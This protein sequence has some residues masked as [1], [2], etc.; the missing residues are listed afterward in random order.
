MITLLPLTRIDQ[1]FTFVD[2][3]GWDWGAGIILSSM[4]LGS[5]HLVDPYP[6]LVDQG[7]VRCHEVREA[8]SQSH[9]LIALSR[10]FCYTDNGVCALRCTIRIVPVLCCVQI[11]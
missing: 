3:T 7:V 11:R 10:P 8:K 5:G 6:S 2:R 9:L 4:G 1:L